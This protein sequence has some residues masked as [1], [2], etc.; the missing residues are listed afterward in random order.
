VIVSEKI[1][2]FFDD[3]YLYCG[4]TYSGHPLA[5]AAAVATIEVYRED[6]LLANAKKVGKYLGEK[7][8]ALKA[9]HPSVGDVRYIGLFSTIELVKDRQSKEPLTDLAGF[10]KYL[11]DHGLFT[12]IFKNMVFIVPP[13]CITEEELD[14]GLTIIEGALA[15]VSDASLVREPA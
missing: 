3:K 1:A 2:R 7:L 5:C 14:E 8:E 13:L 6:G 12:F 9:A 10:G 4:L 11:R 15:Q